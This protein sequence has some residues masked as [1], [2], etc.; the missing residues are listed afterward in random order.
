MRLL[1]DSIA[2]NV[3]LAYPERGRRPGAFEVT[4][5]ASD[6]DAFI[7]AW[8]PGT[9][10]TGVVDVLFGDYKPTSKISF[11]WPKSTDKIPINFDDNNYDPLFPLG[12]GLSY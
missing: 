2:A 4:A 7:A 11:T 8:L 3:E 9:E 6:Y 5:D 10:G 12:Y 1:S